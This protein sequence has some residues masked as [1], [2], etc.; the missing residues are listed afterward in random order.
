M[1]FDQLTRRD[2]TAVLG[3]AAAWP[4]A[5]RAQQAAMPVIWHL[6]SCSPQRVGTIPRRIAFLKVESRRRPTRKNPSPRSEP[7]QSN[8]DS[9]SRARRIRAS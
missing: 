3:G 9:E 6:H 7:T 5:A 8:K 2:F 1:R 4:L